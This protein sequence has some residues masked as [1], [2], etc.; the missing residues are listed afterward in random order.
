MGISVSKSDCLE[1]D[2]I[3]KLYRK[4]VC[5]FLNLLISD[6]AF[7]IVS[8]SGT[9]HQQV[10]DGFNICSDLVAAYPRPHIII[11]NDANA[12]NQVVS[13]VWAFFHE[14]GKDLQSCSFLTQLESQ[15]LLNWY[16]NLSILNKSVSS[17][18]QGF[19]TLSICLT[20]LQIR[21]AS[22]PSS[23]CNLYTRRYLLWWAMLQKC[24]SVACMTFR[25]GTYS[26]SSAI[27]VCWI[28][29]SPSWNDSA[30]DQVSASDV[31]W[32]PLGS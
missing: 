23:R 1:A 4:R 16:K 20:Y 19:I 3:A 8:V 2:C 28:L 26:F 30:A 31:A 9:R 25:F 15:D 22:F 14:V 6:E 17:D 18:M 24:L 21:A 11:T 29:K 7:W 12:D 5:I 32:D 13:S 10:I 27:T